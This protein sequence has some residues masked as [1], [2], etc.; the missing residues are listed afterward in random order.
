MKHAAGEAPSLSREQQLREQAA[1][2][3][4]NMD[5]RNVNENAAGPVIEVL[6]DNTTNVVILVMALVAWVAQYAVV[7]R[8][9]C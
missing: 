1:E 3:D 5:N 7:Q 9:E 2:A 6:G 8:C 4:N